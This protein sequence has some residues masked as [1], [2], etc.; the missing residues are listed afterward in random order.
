MG[1]YIDR[2][3]GLTCGH[4]QAVALR[5]AETDIAAHFWQADAAQQLA[6]RP[7]RR[8]AVV[9]DGAA[10]VARAPEIAV[11][12]AADSVGCAL[13]AVDRE[14][15]KALGIRQRAVADVEDLDVAVAAGAGVSGTL[16]RAGD[17]QAF[18]LG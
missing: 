11:D 3:D 1:I 7:P 12:V 5:P 13:D 4:E 10:G 15:R 9:A 2:I 18:V 16:P 6:V 14:V 17:V 8:H